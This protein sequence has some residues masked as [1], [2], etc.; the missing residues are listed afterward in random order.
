MSIVSLALWM[1]ALYFLRIFPWSAF[2]VRMIVQ[3]IMDVRVFGA[4]FLYSL[5]AFANSFY[6]LGRQVYPHPEGEDASLHLAD[7]DP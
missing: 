1:K 4:I 7:E 2:L 5:L 6:I 3:C